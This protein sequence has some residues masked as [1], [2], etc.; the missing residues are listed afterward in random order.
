MNLDEL[1]KS[2][3][4]EGKKESTL[5]SNSSTVNTEDEKLV[6]E[7]IDPK[8]LEILGIDFTGDLTYGEY[9]TI[10]KE[11]M[12]AQRM[13]GKVDSS[14]AEA[15]TK[16]FRRVKTKNNDKRF[17]VKKTKI[18]ANKVTNKPTSPPKSKKV[19]Y[20]KALPGRGQ[21]MLPGGEDDEEEGCLLYTSDAADE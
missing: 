12:A 17:K 7:V 11:K 20:N 4:D 19:N 21:K 16:E 5:S 2:I 1:L 9:K 18:S 8:V 14:S 3:R 10:L 15:V 6:E 13:G